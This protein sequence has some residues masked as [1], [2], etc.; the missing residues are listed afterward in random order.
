MW[1]YLYHLRFHVFY[2]LIESHL[3]DEITIRV[4]EKNNFKYGGN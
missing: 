4:S 1:L 2:Y 3:L